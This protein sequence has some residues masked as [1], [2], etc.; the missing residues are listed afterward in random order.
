M[1]QAANPCHGISS[2]ADAILN[3]CASFI[4]NLDDDAYTAKSPLQFN[5]TIGQHVRHALDH[6]AAACK[7]QQTGLID[8][9]HRDRDTAIERDR[10]AAISEIARLRD[11]LTSLKPVT[12]TPALRM[13]VMLSGDG[14]CAELDTNLAR[15]VFFAMHHAIHHHAVMGA[16]AMEQGLDI[17]AGFGKAP[18]TINHESNLAGTH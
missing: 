12:E 2:A 8:Y 4:A 10:N 9:D 15:E 5:A 3:Q 1:K 17:P 14:S 16:I 7:G 6:F 18:S 13:Q 11:W